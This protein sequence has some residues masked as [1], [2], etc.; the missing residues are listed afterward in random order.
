MHVVA[1][2]DIV[3]V[4]TTHNQRYPPIIAKGVCYVVLLTKVAVLLIVVLLTEVVVVLT[5]VLFTNVVVVLTV[6]LLTDVVVLWVGAGVS[7]LC[8]R[9]N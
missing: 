5:V 3:E 7:G 4:M 6:V 1:S 8:D 9:R 2:R